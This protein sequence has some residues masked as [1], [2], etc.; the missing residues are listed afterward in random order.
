MT[1]FEPGYSG[2]GSDHA[3]NCAKTTA[4]KTIFLCFILKMENVGAR[5]LQ[6][7]GEAS[8]C[9]I[10]VYR[11]GQDATFGDR[12]HFKLESSLHRILWNENQ[13]VNLFISQ[14]IFTTVKLSILQPKLMSNSLTLSQHSDTNKH[15]LAV[16]EKK[17]QR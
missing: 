15:M 16:L 14:F 12:W 10:E 3:V 13:F 6:H 5:Y 7:Q 8:K 2:I 4:T 17:I 1:G 9:P 11:L